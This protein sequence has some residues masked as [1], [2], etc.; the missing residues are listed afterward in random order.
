MIKG[1]HHVGMATHDIERL[2]A[3]YTD[4]IGCTVVIRFDWEVGYDDGDS[5]VGIVGSS[6]KHAMMRAGNSYIE[7]FQFLTP[8]GRAA[9]PNRPVNDVGISHFCFDVEDVDEE[10]ERLSS[11][12]SG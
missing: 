2:L 4:L 10:Y 8:L 7:I 1:L 3:F 11:S 9:V 6:V 12:R 5:V